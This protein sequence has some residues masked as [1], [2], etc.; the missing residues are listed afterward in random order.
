M[1]T[2]TCN[3]VDGDIFLFLLA[4]ECVGAWVPSVPVREGG[5][6]GGREESEREERWSMVLYA[7][8]IFLDLYLIEWTGPDL[9][10]V[11]DNLYT[12]RLA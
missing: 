3:D 2:C 6:E 5:R 10:V 7:R 4:V 8:T 11:G 1:N 12:G 9:P